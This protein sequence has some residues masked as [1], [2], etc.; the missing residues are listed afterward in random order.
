MLHL[1]RAPLGEHRSR[2]FLGYCSRGQA[3]EYDQRGGARRMCGREKRSGRERAIDREEN[4]FS[5]PEIVEHGGDA[6]GPLLQRR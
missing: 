3:L 2:D 4:C 1:P 5:A 6:V